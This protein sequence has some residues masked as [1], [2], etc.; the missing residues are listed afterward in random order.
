M[1][2]FKPNIKS[3]ILMILLLLVLIFTLNLFVQNFIVKQNEPYSKV[4][5]GG[6][7]NLID[8]SNKIFQSSK[9]DIR[10]LI[11]FGYTYCPDVCPIDLNNVSIIY[12][13]N[14]ELTKKIQPIFI[15]VD[16]ARDTPDVIK[17]YL[18]NFESSIIGLT[19]SKEDIDDVKKKFKIYTNFVENECWK[20]C[21]S[22]IYFELNRQII[23]YLFIYLFTKYGIEYMIYDLSWKVYVIYHKQFSMCSI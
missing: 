8:S 12:K 2:R 13:E 19:G 17:N 14:K 9:L 20:N 5:I 21:I 22:N 11:Y 23:I 15:S 10:K 3:N 7:F 18:A 16:P 1:K 4:Q 6:K